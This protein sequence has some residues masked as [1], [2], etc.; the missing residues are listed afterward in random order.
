MTAATLRRVRY[1]RRPPAD[2]RRRPVA[3]S[4]P[5]ADR[6]GRARPSTATPPRPPG[7]A[8]TCSCSKTLALRRRPGR[9]PVAPRSRR[10]PGRIDVFEANPD[11]RWPQYDRAGRRAVHA[12]AV[13][14]PLRLP[15]AWPPPRCCTCR[16]S[17]GSSGRASTTGPSTAARPSAATP[18]P[19]PT[20]SAAGVDPVPATGRPAHRAG[21]PGPIALLRLP[22]HLDALGVCHATCQTSAGR[23]TVSQDG[24]AGRSRRSVTVG[25]GFA[26][27]AS[28]VPLYSLVALLC[29][30]IFAST[31]P[32]TPRS[33][34]AST[35]PAGSPSRRAAGAPAACSK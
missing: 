21:R 4:P 8:K 26:T 19:W 2:P 14:L 16:W 17:A 5:R 28:P 20:G 33:P 3:V 22:V 30:A 35:P 15:G 18:A 24:I 31:S 23:T 6:H 25:R 32:P 27:I 9:D 10:W 13:R 34:I 12:T 29:L 1:R 11:G 7:G